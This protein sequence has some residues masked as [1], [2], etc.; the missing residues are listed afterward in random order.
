MDYTWMSVPDASIWTNAQ[1]SSIEECVQEA[2]DQ[3]IGY[4]ETIWVAE[5][6]PIDISVSESCALESFLEA[7]EQHVYEQA[8]EVAEDWDIVRHTGRT[9]EKRKE[10][11]EK[12]ESDMDELLRQYVKDIGEWPTFYKI[13]NVRTVRIS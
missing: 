5:C 11:Y 3:G 4:G 12:L 13:V 8:G 9:Y 10:R 7:V 6:E 1:W 2:M